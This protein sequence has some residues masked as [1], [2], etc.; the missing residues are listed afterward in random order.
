MKKCV[1][2][3][4]VALGTASAIFVGG[5]GSAETAPNRD[6]LQQPFDEMVGYWRSLGVTGREV[7]L[8]TVTDGSVSCGSKTITNNSISPA[9]YCAESD[10]EP[11]KIFISDL[12]YEREEGLAK[13]KG[14]SAEAIGAAVIGHELGHYVVNVEGSGPPNELEADCLDGAVI[15]ATAPKLGT[16]AAVFLYSIGSDGHGT[17]DERKAAFENGFNKGVF[18]CSVVLGAMLDIR[19]LASVR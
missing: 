18:G 7:E 1:T 17:G 3:S 12:A 4:V 10:S 19:E 8:Q 16:E 2:G 9:T 13:A 15:H 11:G 14:I 6:T 5:C